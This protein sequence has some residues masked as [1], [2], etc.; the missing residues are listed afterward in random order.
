M[1]RKTGTV[2]FFDMRRGYGFI[3]PDDGG[4]DVF[5]HFTAVS[6]AGLP[7]LLPGMRLRFELVPAMGEG[8]VQADNLLLLEDTQTHNAGR[9]GKANAR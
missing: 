2:K 5:V 1:S 3:M 4:A 8:R 9:K 6:R 7:V